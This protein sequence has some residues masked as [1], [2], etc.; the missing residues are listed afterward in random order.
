MTDQAPRAQRLRG[1]DR[2]VFRSPPVLRT[3]VSLSVLLVGS[4]LFGWYMLPLAVRTQFTWPQVATLAFFV[5]FMVGMMFSLGLSQA[6]ADASGLTVRNC[7]VTRRH[8]WAEIEGVT[9]GSGD[10]WP[11]LQL[12]A[13]DDHPEGRNRMVLGIQRAEGEQAVTRVAQLRALIEAKRPTDSDAS[14]DR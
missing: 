10:A 2:V 7:L 5:L 14:A 3:A 1:D 4:S 11:Y 6:V 13:T 12:G 9:Y 8:P